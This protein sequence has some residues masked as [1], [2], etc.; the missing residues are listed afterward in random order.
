MQV[1]CYTLEFGSILP[2]APKL[3]AEYT[4]GKGT[5]LIEILPHGIIEW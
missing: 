4:P 3:R 2:K 1:S 5:T